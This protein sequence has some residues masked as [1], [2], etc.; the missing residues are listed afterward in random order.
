ML[1][2]GTPVDVL[3]VVAPGAE[4]RGPALSFSRWNKFTFKEREHPFLFP[5]L[6][7]YLCRGYEERVPGA[8]LASFTL[9]DDATPPRGE[10]GA[11]VAPRHREMWHWTCGTGRVELLADP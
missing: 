5:Q 1:A 8:K 10:D 4:P 7:A 2:D 9:V 6:G 11:P 3:A